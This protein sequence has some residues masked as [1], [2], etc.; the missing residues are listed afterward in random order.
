V[1]ERV[2]RVDPPTCVIT[3]DPEVL[4]MGVTTDVA[5]VI[6]FTVGVVEKALL[7]PSLHNTVLAAPVDSCVGA[8]AAVADSCDPVIAAVAEI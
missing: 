1:A 7:E 6:V 8:I 2:V 5:A 3:V 4:M